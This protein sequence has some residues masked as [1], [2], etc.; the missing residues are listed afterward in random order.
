MGR[1]EPSIEATNPSPVVLISLPRNRR[2]WSRT[3]WSRASRSERQL[4]SPI[5]DTRSV[6]PTMS[7]N[8]TVVRTRSIPIPGRSVRNLGIPLATPGPGRSRLMSG[9]SR[10]A[11]RHAHRT[12][13]PSECQEPAD[14]VGTRPVRVTGTE[15]A[16]PSRLVSR[17]TRYP[18]SAE[19]FSAHFLGNLS[20]SLVYV[21]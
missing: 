12:R 14:S 17:V 20:R 6:D 8:S 7:V 4:R 1:S 5:D 9:C 2:R 19:A 11:V 13:A 10:L 16:V 18:A 21:H 15:P 3:I